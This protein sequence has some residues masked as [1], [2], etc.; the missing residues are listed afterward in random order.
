MYS[1][2]EDGIRGLF[3]TGVRRC[4]LPISRSETGRKAIYVNRLMTER[5]EELPRGESDALLA[6]LFDHSE[7]PELR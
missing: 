5:V 3:V 7:K 1:E 2:A 4:A 6:K